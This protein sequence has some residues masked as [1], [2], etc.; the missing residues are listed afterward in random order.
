MKYLSTTELRTKSTELV[1]D[2]RS[3]NSVSLIY[4]SEVVGLI[5][6]AQS[7]SEKV[8]NNFS[9]LEEFIKRA[10]EEGGIKKQKNRLED[11]K[12]IYESHLQQKYG[13]NIS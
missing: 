6:P 1:R 13:Q 8:K 3:G 7:E 10:R 5:S 2:L 12:K 4:R 9:A 11:Q